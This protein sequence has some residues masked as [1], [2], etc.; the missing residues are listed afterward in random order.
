MRVQVLMSSYNGE[1]YIRDQIES[2]LNQHDVE[3]SILIRDDGSKDLTRTILSEI[4]D[5]RITCVYEENI[6]VK[7]SFLKLIAMSD[8]DV[9]Y[10][11]FSD[12]DDIWLE[13]KLITAVNILAKEDQNIPLIYGSSVSLYMNDEVIGEQFVCPQL[14]LGNFLI[15]NYYP[16]CTMVFNRKLIELVNSVDFN[17]LKP[18]PLHDHWLN[19][20]CTACGGKVLMDKEPHILYRQHEGNVIGDRSFIQKIKGNGLLGHS[21]NTRLRICEDLHRLYRDYEDSNSLKQ[22]TTILNY[23]DGFLQRIKLAFSREIKPTSIIEKI[24]IFLIIVM[25]KF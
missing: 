25:G 21:D 6:G 16:G 23:K 24:A 11:A 19:L 5:K 4:N 18:N 3:V 10:Y 20:V 12:Q 13:D 8:P 9:D 7:R 15:K 22:I 2:I 1:K 14:K 17:I